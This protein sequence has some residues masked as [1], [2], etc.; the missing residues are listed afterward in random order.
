MSIAE[1]GHF[2]LP[3]FAGTLI[4]PS[5]AAYDE[6]RRVY[7][8]MIDRRP[9]LIA[10]CNN[11]DDV[12]LALALA[13]RKGLP[14]SVFGGGHAVT[15]SA[16]C[17]DGVC[18]D[19]RGMKAMR[20]DPVA[21]TCRAEAGL[22][23][24]E[25]DAATA[26]HGLVLTGGRN[27]ST[28]IAGLSLGSGSGWLERKFGYVCDNLISAEVVT[29]DGRKVVASESENPDLFWGLRG[30]GGNF[31]TVTAFHFR[32][33]RLGPIVLGGALM[34]PAPMAAAVLRNMRDFIRTAPDEVGMGMAFT[35]APDAPFVPA[36][37]RG[38][39]VVVVQVIYAGD[40][41]EGAQVLAPLRA[42]GPPAADLVQPMPYTEFQKMGGNFPGSQNYWT[43]DFLNE[44]PD[45]AIDAFA[46]L[47]LTPLSPQSAVILVPGGGA[48]SRVD[49]EATAF[50]MRTAP[51]NV[52]YICGWTDP[53]DNDANIARV[54]QI[55]S[56]LKPWSTGRVYLNYIGNEGQERVDASFGA[57]KLARLRALKAKWDPDNVFRHNHNIRPAGVDE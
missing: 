55:A 47:A 25:F 18:I 8:G 45:E 35:T 31:G 5:H 22:N 38:M 12:V 56:V 26:A 1:V 14:V 51:W 27:P 57:M 52:H 6:A 34:Y 53:A 48:P 17:D 11:A 46:V 3:G 4:H 49:E 21:L 9:A 13:R 32:L 19:L 43:A 40:M 36:P 50:G 33:H 2:D 44:L 41:E 30:G 37:A 23:W 20:I 39:P 16:V 7:N 10:R 29:A 28:G 42:F 15:G 54:K 24:G